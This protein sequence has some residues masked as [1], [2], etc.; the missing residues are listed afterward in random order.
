VRT[1][2]AAGRNADAAA[3]RQRFLALWKDADADVPLLN[4]L[5]HDVTSAK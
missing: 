1:L 4:D 2:S 3:A 5:T